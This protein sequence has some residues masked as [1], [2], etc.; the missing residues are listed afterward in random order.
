VDEDILRV[1]KDLLLCSVCV[2]GVDIYSVR[3]DIMLFLCRGTR[4][5]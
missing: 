4:M 5:Y 1:F 2:G 3:K